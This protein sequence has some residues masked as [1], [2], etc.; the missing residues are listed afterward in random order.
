M[1][2]STNMN[3][4]INRLLEVQTNFL[5]FSFAQ[6]VLVVVG[7]IK[8]PLY[9]HLFQPSEI[10]QYSWAVAFI[11]YI[12]II[13]LGWVNSTLWRFVY[14][15]KKTD[16][17]LSLVAHIM[18]IFLI[19]SVI[20][21]SITFIFLNLAILDPIIKR[22]I[23][24]GFFSILSQQILA[25]IFFYFHAYKQFK[26]WSIIIIFQ[27]ICTLILFLILHL[28]FNF[29]IFSIFLSSLLLNTSIILTFLLR[30]FSLLKAV[31]KK[32]KISFKG[33]YFKYSS[34]SIII[35]LCLLILNN[36]DRFLIFHL[37]NENDLGLY[38]Q[39]Y[40]LASVG[41]FS[42]VQAFN[43]YF[44]PNYNSAL[45]KSDS[46]PTNLSVV[47]L[48]ILIFTP[49]VIF[50]I[51][52]NETLISF[53]FNKNFYGYNSVFIWALIGFYVYG[54]YNL[55]EVRMK[56]LNQINKV[57]SALIFISLLNIVAN[58]IFLSVFEFKISSTISFL[59]YLIL[60][61]IAIGN[62]YTFIKELKLKKVILGIII[63][64]GIYYLLH[65]FLV[66]NLV[67]FSTLGYLTISTI[68]ALLIYYFVLYKI[69][70]QLLNSI[71][72]K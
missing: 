69:F 68:L 29:G 2:N 66:Q 15:I 8:I 44:G 41:F 30:Y 19:V 67:S 28:F 65:L 55:L 35:S 46:S 52:N 20:A 31:I 11:S 23:F 32:I 10:G 3:F 25:I 7:I 14:T 71:D 42:A 72:M 37:K 17:F 56:F 22:L 9:T 1:M 49:F 50:L 45:I 13:F 40:G 36:G 48:Y 24:I 6:I 27:Q 62:N 38:S 12:D 4:Y 26:K 16:S 5:F 64:S 58:Y 70:F 43:T 63:A 39:Y 54:I 60:L 21:I 34:L 57:M 18:P 51:I 59:S 53:L 47:E 61:L 33:T